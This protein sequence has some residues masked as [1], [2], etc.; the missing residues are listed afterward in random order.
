MPLIIPGN[1]EALVQ[2]V[3]ARDV[4]ESIALIAE[5]KARG[6]FNCAGDE[7]LSLRGLVEEM[8]RIAGTAPAFRFNSERD[9]DRF[10]EAEFP[11]ANENLICGNSRLKALGARFTPLLKGLEEDYRGYYS[12]AV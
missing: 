6:A 8:A 9:G 1:G 11:F 3:F 2:F 12:K 4:A 7:M 5:K 10:D